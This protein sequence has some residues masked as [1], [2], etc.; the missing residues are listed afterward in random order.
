MSPLK[1]AQS[2]PAQKR[3]LAAIAD[4]EDNELGIPAFIRRKMGG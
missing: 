3:G 4:E 2:E 1:A